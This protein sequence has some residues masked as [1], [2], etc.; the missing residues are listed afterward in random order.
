V[1]SSW[2]KSWV[3]GSPVYGAAKSIRWLMGAR[4]RLRHPEL[5]ELHLEERFMPQVLARLLSPSSC[6]VDVGCHVGSFLAMVL[7]TADK[8]HHV[9]FEASPERSALARRRFPVVEFFSVAVGDRN[10]K[11]TFAEDRDTAGYSHLTKDRNHPGRMSYYEVDVCRLDDILL[12]RERVDLIKLDIEGGEL[13]ALKGA[14]K[15]IAKWH[16]TII[17]E[18]SSEYDLRACGLDRRDLFDLL[19]GHGYE[20][21]TL[22]DLLFDK[23]GMGF[24]EFR[25]CGLYPFRAFNFIA[26]HRPIANHSAAATFAG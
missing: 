1:L 26:L 8:G 13:A 12:D 3:I 2:L 15:L 14:T 16:P 22:T 23:G 25:R 7:Q 5:W 9:A 6:V 10:G 20:I 19:A 11:A 24:D 17:F 4:Q 18:C 21:L